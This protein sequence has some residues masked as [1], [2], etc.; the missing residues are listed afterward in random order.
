MRLLL[1]PL[2]LLMLLQ[3]FHCW[4][5]V[6]GENTT[7]TGAT[8]AQQ[9]PSPMESL[10]SASA[11][12]AAGNSE[13]SSLAGIEFNTPYSHE[14]AALAGV[15]F[16]VASVAV[17]LVLKFTQ[18]AATT[19][20][21][22]KSAATE[23]SA[24]DIDDNGSEVDYEELETVEPGADDNQEAAGASESVPIMHR[25]IFSKPSSN[26][27][28]ES[29]LQTNTTRRKKSVDEAS[30][31]AGRAVASCRFSARL[32]EAN[33]LLCLHS[34]Q[35]S[36]RALEDYERRDLSSWTL[37][38]D[39]VAQT[40]L[41]CRQMRL[42]TRLMRATC[43]SSGGWVSDAIDDVLAVRVIQNIAMNQPPKGRLLIRAL[44]LQSPAAADSAIEPRQKRAEAAVS[45]ILKLG[46][47]TF[48]L[49]RIRR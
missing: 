9:H 17:V 19:E 48:L 6:S 27:T 33:G 7:T 46:G 45:S 3:L 41:E 5:R 39:I 13:T 14:I 2:L 21:E 40:D 1:V 37:A 49:D 16:V 30:R 44:A 43:D 29:L 15:L 32:D 28:Y 25:F 20:H 4:Q 11:G 36:L 31:D 23:D 12:G 8:A 18:R 47:A 35:L 38:I 10:S 34:F 24:V 22:F 42:Q 26:Y